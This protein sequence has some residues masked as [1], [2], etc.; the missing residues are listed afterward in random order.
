MSVR[1][2]EAVV[3]LSIAVASPAATL[4]DGSLGTLPGSQ[5]W[6]L[7]AM[8]LGSYVESLTGGAAALTTTGTERAGYTKLSP[9]TL[10]GAAGYQFTFEL[11]LDT[12]S[13]DSA[14]RAGLSVLLVGSDLL[15][16]EIAFWTNEVWVQNA[17]F[18]HGEGASFD[19]T[20]RTLYTLTVAG[21]AYSLSAGGAP[22]LTGAL[23]DYS[24]QG[25]PYTI[26]NLLFVGDDTFSA[27]AAMRFY[28]AGV[29]AL[30]E[31]ATWGWGAV[32][33][34]ALAFKRIKT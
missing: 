6:T 7:G 4:Y 34:L 32:S 2:R 20:Q 21:G 19:A 33:L 9:V 23:R 30:P 13:H 16:L 31:P 24:A 17:G 8:G 22:L 25:M 1:L 15:G 3:L 11:A 12:E 18:T 5:G 14:D 29:T 27:N 10:D 28:Q 26:P